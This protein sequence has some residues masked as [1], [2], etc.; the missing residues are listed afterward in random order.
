[1]FVILHRNK[2]KNIGIMRN[3]TLFLMAATA[4][5]G[6][7]FAQNR[8]KNL[9][10]ST[11][12]LNVSILQENQPVQINRTL[13]AGYNSICLPMSLNAEQLQEAAPEVQ[14]ERLAAIR[15]EGSVLNLYFMDCT[16]EGIE[17]GVPYLIFSPKFQTLRANSTKAGSIGTE[18]QCITKTDGQ[19][20]QVTFGSSWESVQVADR[21]GI[22]ARQDTDILQSILIR[23]D[24]NNTFLPTRCGFTWDSQSASATTMEIKHIASLEGIE[25]SIQGLQAKNANVSIYNTNGV[26]VQKGNINTALSTLPAGIYVIGG[27]KVAVK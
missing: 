12:N 9:Y 13:F 25:T 7:A 27:Q 10:T 16:A 20:N 18:L 1:M 8:V 14:V 6:Q 17:A 15:Q 4:F 24:G 23:T 3:F 19:G 21:Y 26:L 22:P 11:T 2:P 5:C